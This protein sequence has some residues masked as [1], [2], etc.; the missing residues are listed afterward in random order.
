MS[1]TQRFGGADLRTV[2]AGILSVVLLIISG[3]T[4]VERNTEEVAQVQTGATPGSTELPLVIAVGRSDQNSE[5]LARVLAQA[6][7]RTVAL[8]RLTAPLMRRGLAEEAAVIAVCGALGQVVTQGPTLTRELLFRIIFANLIT[9]FHG[10]QISALAASQGI[11]NELSDGTADDPVWARAAL[12]KSGH[13]S[14]RKSWT[15]SAIAG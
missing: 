6:E 3:C 12:S 7:E 2:G 9:S 10:D 14:P 13:C 8:D 5:D 11:V 1:P 15:D 4:T